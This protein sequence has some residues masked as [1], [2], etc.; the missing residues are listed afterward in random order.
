M[1]KKSRKRRKLTGEQKTRIWC[2]IVENAAPII[3]AFAALI[4]VLVPIMI[5]LIE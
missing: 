3:R 5:I 2:T 4:A 1:G